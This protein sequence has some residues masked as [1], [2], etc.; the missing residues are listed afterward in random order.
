[1]QKQNK[2]KHAQT[3]RAIHKGPKGHHEKYRS[4]ESERGF[5]H[6]TLTKNMTCLAMSRM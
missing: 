3:I 1:M 2:A 5:D 4:K 6:T